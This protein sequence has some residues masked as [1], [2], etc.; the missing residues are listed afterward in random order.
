MP[1]PSTPAVSRRVLRMHMPERAEQIGMSVR[2]ADRWLNLDGGGRG[3]LDTTHF[4]TVRFP[5]PA[6][7]AD[8]MGKTVASG[9]LAYTPYRGHPGVLDTLA[10]TLGG[11]LGVPLSPAENLALT[12]GT[13]ASL[14]ATLSAL[15]DE[16]DL[17]LAADPDYLFNE[18]ILAFLGARVQRVPVIG[19]NG[20][21]PRLDLAALAQ[22]CAQR[23]KLMLF[24][25]PSNPA[26]IA[27][28]AGTIDAIAE[29][30]QRWDFRVVV[31]SLYCRLIYDDAPFQHLIARPGMLERC[32]TLVG[33]SKT[34]SM[35]GYRVGVTV[36]PADVLEAV[37][38]VLAAMSLR[39]P[40]YAQQLLSHWWTDDLQFVAERIGELR[41][42]RELSLGLLRQV[43]YLRVHSPQAT[44]YLFPDV[45][46]L[47]LPDQEVAARLQQDAKVIVSP[48]YQFGPAGVGHFRVCFAR[49]EAQWEEALGRMVTVLNALGEERGVA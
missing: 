9:E 13:Q 1:L 11:A 2:E 16:G 43:P 21:A 49:D 35:S 17:V 32:V 19:G 8:V 24:T 20:G 4:D 14:F 22:A 3:L 15:V 27:Y 10:A 7:A 18:R 48:G 44:A 12:P 47:G 38:P 29:L 23:P 45:S 40:A 36:G 39:A 6:W 28:D 37:E 42:L 46:A 33:P 25:N 34:E 30:A 41:A 31:D 26:G 5:P